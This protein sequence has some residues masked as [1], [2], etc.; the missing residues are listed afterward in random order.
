MREENIPMWFYVATVRV[1]AQG[2]FNMFVS[3]W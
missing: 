3:T 1:T 2:W